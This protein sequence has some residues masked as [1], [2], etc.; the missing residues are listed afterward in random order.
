MLCQICF[1]NKATDRHHMMSNS[2]INRQLYGKLLDNE[3]NILHVCNGC[4]LN[5]D[6]PKLDERS[7]CELLSINPR[8]KTERFK[9][10]TY[11]KP[12]K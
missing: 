7:F 2:K 8:S 1:K 6:I 4:H 10:G 5:K 9:N 3:K 11:F 12:I